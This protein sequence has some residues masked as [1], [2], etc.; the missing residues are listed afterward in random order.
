MASAS[1]SAATAAK[2]DD[3]P[4]AIFILVVTVVA[5]II[6]F[7]MYSRRAKTVDFRDSQSAFE[8]PEER[9]KYEEAKAKLDLNSPADVE[10]LKKLLMHR[11]LKVIPMLLNLQNEGQSVDRLYRKGMLTDDVHYKMKELKAFVD[12]EIADVQQEAALLAKGWEAH[13]WAQA[14]TFHNVSTSFACK[15]LFLLKPNYLI[16]LETDDSETIWRQRCWNPK[17]GREKER[18]ESRSAIYIFSSSYG[19]N[20][21]HSNCQVPS[22]NKPSNEKKKESKP[23]KQLKDLAPKNA[24]DEEAV[25]GPKSAAGG[26]M[27]TDPDE[28]KAAEAERMARQL[29][30]VILWISIL[31]SIEVEDI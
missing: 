3:G 6:G 26:A 31:C 17:G 18:G 11:A 23:R 30:E 9:A 29:L 10:V 4:I 1:E 2:S 25:T 12:A 15:Y 13:V 27:I 19:Q 21:K 8:P 7:I 28:L 16:F 14:M 24:L 5:V 20:F 22:T